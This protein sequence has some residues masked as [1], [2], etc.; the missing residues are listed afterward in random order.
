MDYS[1]SSSFIPFD[2]LQSLLGQTG[3]S[4][5]ANGGRVRKVC[6]EALRINCGFPQNLYAG[7]R[8][9]L[10]EHKVMVLAGP[11]KAPHRS[12][13][14]AAYQSQYPHAHSSSLFA[15]WAPIKRPLQATISPGHNIQPS[16]LLMPIFPSMLRR[17]LECGVYGN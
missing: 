16:C 14:Y 15:A 5:S 11:I 8:G 10:I 1:S 13:M 17:E 6:I 3:V 4:Q 12:R 7:Q 2:T 9:P